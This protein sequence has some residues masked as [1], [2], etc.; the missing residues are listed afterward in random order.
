[1]DLY[2][3]RLINANIYINGV[4]LLGRASDIE[5]PQIKHKMDE[6][7]GLGMAGSPKFWLGVDELEAKINFVWLDPSYLGAVMN[8]LRWAQ[9]MVRGYEQQYTAGGMVAEVPVIAML[10]GVWKE[11]PKVSFKPHEAQPVESALTVYYYLL[12]IGGLPQV[13]IDVLVN[14]FKVQGND[15]LANF[16]AILGG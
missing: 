7:K 9:I 13:E 8:P 15:V 16:R 5:L 14:V 2:A 11:M 3:A 4:D 12:T 10:T 1:M 6:Y